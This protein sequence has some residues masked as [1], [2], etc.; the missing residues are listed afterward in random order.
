MDSGR[1]GDRDFLPHNARTNNQGKTNSTNFNEGT[2]FNEKKT[3]RK[4]HNG[5]A[6][7]SCY[8]LKEEEASGGYFKAP[9][10]AKRNARERR[11]VEAVNEAFCKLSR[12][13]PLMRSKDR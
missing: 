2:N 10:T 6:Q 13:V 11:R 9:S 4:A 7:S 5:W 1:F 3:P 12:L 8:H